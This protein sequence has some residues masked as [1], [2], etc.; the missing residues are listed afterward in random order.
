MKKLLIITCL[1]LTVV[2]LQSYGADY[3]N[4]IAANSGYIYPELTSKPTFTFNPSPGNPGGTGAYAKPKTSYTTPTPATSSYNS[5]KYPAIPLIAEF[6]YPDSPFPTL[7]YNSTERNLNYVFSNAQEYYRRGQYQLARREIDKVVPHYPNS[8]T[9]MMT[10]SQIEDALG[11]KAAA[12]EYANNALGLH[13]DGEFYT[14]RAYMMIKQGDASKIDAIFKD[15]EQAGTIGIFSYDSEAIWALMDDKSIPSTLK[16]DIYKYYIKKGSNINKP[17]AISIVASYIQFIYSLDDNDPLFQKLGKTKNQILT[18]YL[19]TLQDR[20]AALIK[21]IMKVASGNTFVGRKEIIS[22]L[23]KSDKL[24]HDARMAGA[25]LRILKP[26]PRK[27]DSYSIGVKVRPAEKKT[28]DDMLL[29]APIIITEIL[30][31]ELR[32]KGIREGDKITKING[33]TLAS[34]GDIIDV[35]EYMRGA[36]DSIIKIEIPRIPGEIELKRT[37]HIQTELVDYLILPM[38]VSK[39]SGGYESFAPIERRKPSGML[40]YDYNEEKSYSGYKYRM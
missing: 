40:I 11:N 12:L 18:G 3:R 19:A 13:Q 8:P 10:K 38:S 29:G 9:I 14:W 31:P 24:E 7:L 26:I 27:I 4:Y 39:S 5:T 1:M 22:A 15:L 25:S 21:A 37:Y 28:I 34:I 2:E 35:G 23:S 6:G 16:A 20:D 32:A 36:K 17:R 30:N 33:K